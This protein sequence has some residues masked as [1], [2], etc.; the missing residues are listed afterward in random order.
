MKAKERP[1][2]GPL[3]IPASSERRFRQHPNTDSGFTRTL[4]PEA[5]E[6]AD[7]IE[8]KKA[9]PSHRAVLSPAGLWE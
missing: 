1:L 8:R 7:Q 3:R 5:S 4:I 6:P 9:N 2:L